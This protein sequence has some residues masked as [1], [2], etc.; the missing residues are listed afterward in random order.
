MHMKVHEFNVQPV[1]EKWLGL[2][3]RVA[4]GQVTLNNKIDLWDKMYNHKINF[5]IASLSA[6]WYDLHQF[7]IAVAAELVELYASRCCL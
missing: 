3:P 5:I 7:R 4:H 6:L 1:Q 2:L